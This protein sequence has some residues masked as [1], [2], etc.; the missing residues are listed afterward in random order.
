MIQLSAIPEWLGKAVIG[1]LIAAAGYCAKWF[2]DWWKSRMTSQRAR[3]DQLKEL[4]FQLQESLS[5]FNAQNSQARRLIGLLREHHPSQE[6]PRPGFEPY[7]A[8]VY[9]AF[10]EEE[11]ELHSI[12]RGLTENSVR[13]VNESMSEWL[14]K[15]RLLRSSLNE[16]E[17]QRK[18]AQALTQLEDHLDQ[19][20][21]KYQIWIPDQP[22]HA[23]VYLAAEDQHGTGFPVGIEKLL[24]DALEEY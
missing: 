1:A 21:S 11:R 19:W 18:L 14:K 12:I 20:T 4:A 8:H 16:T 22:K 10:T 17:K 2:L 9:D 24:A 13:R 15:N 6:P 23:L 3:K 7:F 5:L